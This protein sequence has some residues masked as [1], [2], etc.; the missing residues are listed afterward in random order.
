M[1]KEFPWYP[2]FLDVEGRTALVVGGGAVALRKI[3]TLLH[4]GAAVRVV[5]PQVVPEI[6]EWDR[7]GR[8]TLDRRKYESADVAGAAV[9]IAATDDATVNA[10]V[11]TDARAAGVPV[12]VVDVPPLSTFI[13]PAVIEEGSIQIAVSTGGNSPA[14]A[15]RLKHDLLSTAAGYGAL[16]E[17]MGSLR[18]TAKDTL[19]TDA[20]RKHFFD[21]ILASDALALLRAG[22]DEAAAGTIAAICNEFGI[23]AGGLL[24]SGPKRR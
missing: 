1:A 3:E 9:A 19:P 11:A 14:L 21:A 20:D 7:E 13:V 23:D 18:A 2:I 8:L 17:I 5:S 24:T 22:D 6:E 10:Q 15:R 4:Y 16:S 12:N